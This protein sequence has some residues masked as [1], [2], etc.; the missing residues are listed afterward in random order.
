MRHSVFH[1]FE[2]IPAFLTPLVRALT[3]QNHHPDFSCNTGLNM[4]AVARTT[5]SEQAITLADLQFARTL[6]AWARERWAG[7]GRSCRGARRCWQ[8]TC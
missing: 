4:V 1:P 7:Y 6:N 8:H 3:V 5:P 2:E